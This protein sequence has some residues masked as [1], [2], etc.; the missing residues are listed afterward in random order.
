MPLFKGSDPKGVL[1]FGFEGIDDMPRL[2]GL[3]HHDKS[4]ATIERP[5]HFA[6]GQLRFVG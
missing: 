4:N 1:S 2:C 5:Q 6:V 3:G